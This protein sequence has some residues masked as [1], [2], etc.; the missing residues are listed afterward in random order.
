MS[1]GAYQILGSLQYFFWIHAIEFPLI[2]ASGFNWINH[3]HR[4]FWIVG[5][6]AKFSWSS[7]S[8]K[9]SG[10]PGHEYIASN[11]GMHYLPF[12]IVF[13]FWGTFPMVLCALE[14]WVSLVLHTINH[15][16]I[17][18]SQGCSL[19]RQRNPTLR[20]STTKMHKRKD[21]GGKYSSICVSDLVLP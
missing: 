6:L 9:A 5:S 17:K 16:C 4:F 10:W 7:W 2:I 1:G 3:A 14:S 11:M 18:L 21:F 15:A 12:N 19:E 8:P 20:S 13:F